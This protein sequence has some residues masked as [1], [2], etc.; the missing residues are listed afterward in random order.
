MII[1]NS[2]E[3]KEHANCQFLEV[4]RVEYKRL[5]VPWWKGRWGIFR[6][7]SQKYAEAKSS[8]SAVGRIAS[9][10]AVAIGG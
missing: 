3:I 8:N 7:D 10:L 1:K 4:F 5:T 9:D 6:S 2:P